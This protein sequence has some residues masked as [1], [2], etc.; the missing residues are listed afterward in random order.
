[1]IVEEVVDGKT[2]GKRFHC[3]HNVLEVDERRGVVICK[4]C[5][6]EMSPLEALKLLYR[7]IWWEENTRERQIEYDQKRVSKV[8]VA[9]LICL[10]EAGVTPEKYA[11]RWNKEHARRAT[12]EIAKVAEKQVAIDGGS[13]KPVA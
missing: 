1:V 4:T 8:Q 7:T 6:D 12:L 11:E 13:E 2:T 9:A 3:E 10:Y 5:G